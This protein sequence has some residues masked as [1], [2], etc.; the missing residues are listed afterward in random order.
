MRSYKVTV[1]MVYDTPTP[2]IP[3]GYKIKSFRPVRL[4]DTYLCPW[5]NGAVCA[6]YFEI[7][8]GPFLILKPSGDGA[9]R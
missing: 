3:D 2:E 6:T 9:P 5:G 1:E 8:W 7:P 4:N